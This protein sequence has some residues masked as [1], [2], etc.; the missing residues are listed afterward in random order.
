[1]FNVHWL[2]RTK[3]KNTSIYIYS[4]WTLT[5]NFEQ[6]VIFDNF[7]VEFSEHVS[8]IVDKFEELS[9]YSPEIILANGE[10]WGNLKREKYIFWWKSLFLRFGSHKHNCPF[11]LPKVTC[12]TEV[13]KLQ[14][15]NGIV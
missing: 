14:E 15:K 8:V 12:W 4:F 5:F 9:S 13:N 2:L 7:I 10:A 1:M 11:I 3:S 6:A